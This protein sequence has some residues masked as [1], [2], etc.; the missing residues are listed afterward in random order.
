MSLRIQRAY[1]LHRQG[2]KRALAYLPARIAELQEQL[3][4]GKRI[5]RASDDASDFAQVRRLA[6]AQERLTQL[7][8]TIEQ[9][10][11]W[12][13]QGLDV[14]NTISDVLSSIY[15]LGI[16]G[17][18]ETMSQED[19]ALLAERILTLKEE[20]LS[21]ANAKQGDQYLFGGTQT[22]I[23]PFEKQETGS[24]IYKGNEQPPVR[25]LTDDQTIPISTTGKD[26][27][28]EGDTSLFERIDALVSALRTDTPANISKAND[29]LLKA[30]DHILAVA[31]RQGTYAER[32][33]KAEE[34]TMNMEVYLAQQ[35]SSL[36]D[37][38]MVRAVTEFQRNQL[39]YQSALK[40]TSEVIR[41]SLVNFI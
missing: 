38:D 28:Y 1:N 16:Q 10:R 2:T 32:L 8:R 27:F 26:L 40:A 13:S 36:E 14:M 34:Q 4:T 12:L 3:T 18:T 25:Q 33:Q 5:N 30:R 23:P 29:A 20:I 19:R 37:T 22:Q 9:A 35:R 6:H 7:K 15:E 41:I 21:L 31:A 24:I 39:A 17:A 11:A